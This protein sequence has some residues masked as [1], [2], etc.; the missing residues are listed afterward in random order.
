MNGAGIVDLIYEAAFVP[1][2][3]PA[4]LE[5]LCG[6]SGSASGSM[7]IFDGVSAPRWK[8]TERTTEVLTRFA[9]TDAWRRSERD[10]VRL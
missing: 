1:E 7:L 9:A 4:V 2:H 3:W 5:A 8:T 6:V 10:P